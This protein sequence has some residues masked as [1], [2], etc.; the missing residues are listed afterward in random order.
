[1]NAGI[2]CLNWPARAGR[3]GK[4]GGQAR[5]GSRRCS[6]PGETEERKERKGKGRETYR[7]GRHVSGRGEKRKRMAGEW[8]AAGKGRRDVGPLGRKVTLFLFSPF[9]FQTFFNTIFF[10]SNSNQN[11]S[12][13]S[14]NFINLLYFTQATKNYAK[15]NNDAQTLVVSKLIKLN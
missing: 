9:L 6:G 2:N 15:L 3:K 8:A 4:G 5:R 10:K 1:L 14:Q 11:P 13:F 7:R 12:N